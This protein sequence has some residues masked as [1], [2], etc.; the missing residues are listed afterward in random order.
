MESDTDVALPRGSGVHY[1]QRSLIR[2][3]QH[4]GIQ[5]TTTLVRLVALLTVPLGLGACESE[6]VQP[7]AVDAT[8]DIADS[9]SADVQPEVVEEPPVIPYSD[10][11]QAGPWPVGI[12]TFSFVDPQT[13]TPRAVEVWH[14]AKEKA[15]A[16][17]GYRLFEIEVPANGYR[18]VAQDP[19]APNLLVGFSHG[20]GGMRWQNYS[21]CERLAS[22]G[23]VVVASDHPGTTFQE[24]LDTYGKA[25]TV[26]LPRPG[27]LIE[28]LDAALDGTFTGIVPRGKQFALVGH[29]LGSLTL[30]ANGGGVLT[31][32]QY[33][34]GCEEGNYGGCGLMGP[35]GDD[36]PLDSTAVVKKDP[37]IVTMVL[38]ALTGTYAFEPESL[39][40]W[41]K[42]LI[43][44]GDR[45]LGAPKEGATAAFGLAGPGTAMAVLAN[46]GH[47]APTDIC[48]IP[49]AKL[50]GPDCQWEKNGFAE[51]TGIRVV[52]TTTT[53]AWLAT[54]FGGQPKFAD[55][56]QSRTGLTWQEK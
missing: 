56:L 7:A 34:S 40:A 9:E 54:H 22:F 17:G 26:L 2:P 21:M 44:S 19:K 24:I 53:L 6:D 39:K 49:G 28:I 41:P 35:W 3:A 42:S 52:A 18:D 43:L 30:M 16:M 10:P 29:S 33:D 15:A 50:M 8:P 46:A 11:S 47:N 45:D 13:G 37:R 38:Q 25:T 23:F 36:M 31:K 27:D 32:E 55:H 48:N 4:V 14:P 1:P 20:Y 5:L 12:R 51:P